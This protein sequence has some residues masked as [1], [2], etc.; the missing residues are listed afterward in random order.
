MTW[1][2]LLA[3]NIAIAV[4]YTAISVLIAN[5]LR[6]SGQLGRANPLGT[7][8]A[9]IFLSCAVGHGAHA[10]HLAVQQAARDLADIH[11]LAVDGITALIAVGYL[12]LRS[13]FDALIRR[14]A[15]FQDVARERAQRSTREAEQLFRTSFDSA[16]IGMALVALDGR[17]LRTNATLSRITGWAP[18]ELRDRRF[19]DITHPVDRDPG[20]RLMERLLA[21]EMSVADSRKRYQRPD[22]TSVLVNLRVAVVHDA[23]GRPR[24]FVAQ[25]E[26]LS[27]EEAARGARDRARE[28]FEAVFASAPHGSCIVE[29]HDGGVGTVDRVNPAL[30]SLIGPERQGMPVLSLVAPPDRDALALL[31]ERAS[32]G[33]ATHSAEVRLVAS[34]GGTTSA[35]VS[36]AVMAGDGGPRRLVLQVVDITDRLQLE[37]R[38]R[39]QADHDPLTMLFNRRRFREEVESALAGCRRHAHTG[40]VLMLDLDGFK[41]V[42]DS[43]GHSAGDELIQ[44]TSHVL[45]QLVRETDVVARLG[46]DEFA[47][48]LT[49]T[50]EA[51]ART[52]AEKLVDG[53]ARE[54][55]IL[56]SGRPARI[57]CSIGVTTFDGAP[58]LS[59]EDLMAEADIAMYEA[60]DAGRNTARVFRASE[61]RRE[62]LTERQ[63]WLSALRAGLTADRFELLAQ[64][65]VPMGVEADPHYEL[66]LR[67][68]DDDGT[69]VAPGTFLYLAERFDL[70]REIDFWVIEQAALLLAEDRRK[71]GR[72]ILSV[73]VS[74]R[75]IGDDRL[76]D[77]LRAMVARHGFDP[78]RL[79][80]EIT[81]T[82]A[83]SNMDRARRVADGL[84]EVGCRLALDDFGAGFA[85]FYYLK[86]LR[87]DYLKIDGEFI[88]GLADDPTDQLVVEAI[89]QI[90]RGLGAVTVAEF[91]GD[92]RTVELLCRLG[93]D[94]GQG[95]HLG[96]P[97]AMPELP[98]PPIPADARLGGATAAVNT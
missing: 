15:M 35:L 28:D 71:G 7:M 52:V 85:S 89:V 30:A 54:A 61:R 27:K 67:Y 86:H 51:G 70:I 48:L 98:Q 80:L 19:V 20:L 8:T 90:A 75:T 45:R 10:E 26:D 94:R 31:L 42:N 66:L 3:F 78:G 65:I 49:E 93:V 97:A 74:G 22:G 23:D 25:I 95:Y 73:N 24:H 1:Q 11:L 84:R 18:E 37:A 81:E 87:F 5:G 39:H 64:P 50:D 34:D 56:T 21:G 33:D 79:V 58:L 47:V 82:A 14:P 57:T 88:R 46:G 40:A 63:R 12:S 69:L 72:I 13:R 17:F 68:R 76:F 83:I 32:V 16:P 6:R 91:V 92:D 2:L 43:Y 44:R 59:P 77:H 38:L 36:V 53:I 41:Y 9:A 4:A 62:R 60:K 96:M 29:L 55:S